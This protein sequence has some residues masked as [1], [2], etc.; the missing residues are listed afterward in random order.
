M[1]HTSKRKNYGEIYWLK[2]HLEFIQEVR[3]TAEQKGE[4]TLAKSCEEIIKKYSLEG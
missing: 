2:D 3:D 1:A 4:S